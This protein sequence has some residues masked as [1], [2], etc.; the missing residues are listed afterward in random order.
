MS[1]SMFCYVIRYHHITSLHIIVIVGFVSDSVGFVP[2][3]LGLVLVSVGID[4]Y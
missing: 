1:M 3:W 4:P 2:V